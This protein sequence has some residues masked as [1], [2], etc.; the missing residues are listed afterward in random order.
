MFHCPP[1]GLASYTSW[2]DHLPVPQW[3]VESLST[4]IK[5]WGLPKSELDSLRRME[6]FLINSGGYNAL[7]CTRVFLNRM[8]SEGKLML[9]IAG[10]CWV[11]NRRVAAIFACVYWREDS[12]LE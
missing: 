8:G 6:D 12:T 4:R 9:L 7:Q 1:S 2:L 5:Q 10:Y 3:I 11:R